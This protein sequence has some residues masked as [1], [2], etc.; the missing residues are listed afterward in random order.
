MEKQIQNNCFTI[1]HVFLGNLCVNPIHPPSKLCMLRS[2][3]RELRDDAAA[4]G[5][6]STVRSR[7]GV[8]LPGLSSSSFHAEDQARLT[9]CPGSC[10]PKAQEKTLG[11]VQAQ[12]SHGERS[13]SLSLF[14][15]QIQIQQLQN[16][17]STDLA[18]ECL[19]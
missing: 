1:S 16:V 11:R 19:L 13:R 10:A 5:G 15:K 2:C 4:R 12:R 8:E 17:W 3:A 9:D 6:G 7:V 18:V 14:S